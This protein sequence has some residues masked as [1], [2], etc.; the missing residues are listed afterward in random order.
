MLFLFAFL[1]ICAFI[2]MAIYGSFGGL[3]YLSDGSVTYH[4]YYSFGNLGFTKAICGNS[5]IN[6]GNGLVTQLNF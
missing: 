2:Q 3:D 1:S 6:W 5:P 4:T